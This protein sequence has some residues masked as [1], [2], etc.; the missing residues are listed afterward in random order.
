MNPAARFNF[1][2]IVFFLKVQPEFCIY[3]K[4]LLQTNSHFSRDGGRFIN[5]FGKLLSAYAKSFGC[6]SNC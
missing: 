3:A 2:D 4:T 6:L 1:P 5:Y